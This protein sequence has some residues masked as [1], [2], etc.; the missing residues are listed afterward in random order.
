MCVDLNLKPKK[1]ENNDASLAESSITNIGHSE[2]SHMKDKAIQPKHEDNLLKI[3]PPFRN[4]FINLTKEN[5][6]CAGAQAFIRIL[7]I[8]NVFLK[9]FWAVCLL[10]SNLICGYLVVQTLLTYLSF[11]VFTKTTTVHETPA[12]FPK[13]TICNSAFATTEYALNLIKEINEE[14]SPNISIFD[15]NQLNDLSWSN[16]QELMGNI[17]ETYFNKVNYLPDESKKKLV[18]SLDDILIRCLFGYHECTSADF[19]WK[20]DP[21]YGNCYSFNS[22]FNSNE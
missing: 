22:G 17:Y 3:K 11:P 18:H 12:V 20:Y 2:N 16:Q 7:D 1:E 13:I 19:V 8:K 21:V 4:L 9:I 10:G 14:K 5:V 6:G 15:E